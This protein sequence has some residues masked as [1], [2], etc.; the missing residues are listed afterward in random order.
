LDNNT[1]KSLTWHQRVY[2]KLALWDHEERNA[3]CEHVEKNSTMS[4]LMDEISYPAMMDMAKVVKGG[5]PVGQNFDVNDDDIQAWISELATNDVVED[6]DYILFPQLEQP[7]LSKDLFEDFVDIDALDVGNAST[8]Q[9]DC[10]NLFDLNNLQQVDMAKKIDF[11]DFFELGTPEISDEAAIASKLLS[12]DDNE[13]TDLLISYIE[14]DGEV[15]SPEMSNETVDILLDGLT[16]SPSNSLMCNDNISDTGATETD[17]LPEIL[18]NDGTVLANE[19]IIETVKC[20]VNLTEDASIDEKVVN[21]FADL[22]NSINDSLAKWDSIQD[23]SVSNTNSS[24]DFVNS[25][26]SANL[27]NTEYSILPFANVYNGSELTHTSI[28]DS[29]NSPLSNNCSG[30]NIQNTESSETKKK[31]KRKHSSVSSSVSSVDDDEKISLRRHKNNEAS[32]LTRAKRKCRHKDLFEQERRLLES[33]AE[34]RIKAE[35]MQKEADILREL[36]VVALS[37]VNS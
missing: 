14:N 36:L 27:C 11:S 12:E 31:L 15:S 13:I 21:E 23:T 35:V 17:L 7:Q 34:L 1:K 9:N 26:I 28:G 29:V 22:L 25:L 32:K 5:V 20:D 30:E 16:S 19:Q 3:I 33:N 4:T 8:I 10:N 24:V 6:R 2:K 37:N 18:A